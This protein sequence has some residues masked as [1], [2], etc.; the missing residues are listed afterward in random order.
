[1]KKRLKVSVPTLPKLS[2]R[3]FSESNNARKT[4]GQAPGTL[5]YTG[6]KREEEVQIEVF[7]YNVESLDERKSNKIDEALSIYD[8]K[9]V[10]WINVVGLH[11]IELIH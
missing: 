1:M 10:N 4:I 5:I 6:K 2:F 11:N 3:R 9:R 7:T 8:E